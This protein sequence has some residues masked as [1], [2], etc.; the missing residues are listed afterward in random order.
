MAHPAPPRSDVSAGVGLAGLAGLLAW[1]LVCRNWPAVADALAIPGPRQ[2]LSGPY[3]SLAALLFSAVP[4]VL[5]SLCV[6]KVH[7][8]PATGI[9]WSRPRARRDH[10]GISLVKL[11]G[12]WATWAVI[13]GAYCIA[14]YYWQEP[15]LFAIHVL[16]AAAVPMVVLSVP[17]VFWIDRY[18]MEPRDGAW[19][20]GALLLGRPGADWSEVARHT[21]AWAV[22]GFFTAFMVS[23]LPSGFARIVS[24][25]WHSLAGDPVHTSYWLCEAMF[26]FDVQIGMVGYILTLRPLAAQIRSAQPRLAGWVAALICYPPFLLMNSGGPLDYHAYTADWA[27]WLADH[28]AL[29]WGWGMLL[30]VLTGCYAWATFAFGLRFSNLTYRGVLTNGPYRYTKHPAYLS[31]NLFWWASTM[32]MLVTTHSLVDAVR[33]TVILAGVSAVY[34][35]RAR[36]E[37]AHIAG[38]DPKYRA[39]AEWMAEH[40]LLTAPLTRLSRWLVR[41]LS[42]P[43]EVPHPAE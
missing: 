5:W 20:C 22:K 29:L 31:K 8:D 3:A 33:N 42:V 24:F 25:D 27:Y 21:R 23:I 9:D 43:A 32:P 13:G 11:V 41:S 30:V 16:A 39:Y 15:Y 35:W 10:F 36:T 6:D 40:G 38:E 34:W 37:E 7:R 26:L 4:M 18:L 1:L 17:Y 28:P 12:L 19:H 14:R 2:P